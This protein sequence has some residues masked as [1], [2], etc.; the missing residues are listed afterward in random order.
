MYWLFFV[1]FVIKG[2]HNKFTLVDTKV[3]CD[4]CLY[5]CIKCVSIS[6]IKQIRLGTVLRYWSMF[7]DEKILVVGLLSSKMSK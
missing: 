6:M 5:V 4:V 1:L 3:I 7:W 2:N